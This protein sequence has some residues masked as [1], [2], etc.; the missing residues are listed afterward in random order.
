LFLLNNFSQAS[1]YYDKALKRDPITTK[2]Y[3]LNTGNDLFESKDYH[4]AWWLHDYVF[5]IDPKIDFDWLNR[6]H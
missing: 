2:I 4:K 6:G 5:N 1:E 3:L